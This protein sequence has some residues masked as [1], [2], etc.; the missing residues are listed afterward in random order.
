MNRFYLYKSV[1][2]KIPD[3]SELAQMPKILSPRIEPALY[4]VVRVQSSSLRHKS[5]NYEAETLIIFAII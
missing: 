2:P 4:P 1:V 5:R 3:D